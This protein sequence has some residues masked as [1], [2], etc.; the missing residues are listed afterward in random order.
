MSQYQSFPGAA[1]AS[2]TLDKLKA[3]RL[4]ELRGK[5]FLDVGCNEGFFCGFAQML[6][7]KRVVGVDH[8]QRFI[9][10]ARA[11]F[12]GC[13]FLHQ[14]WDCLP[15]GPFDVIL[16]ASALHYADDQEK[17]IHRL[18]EHLSPEGTLIVELGI[19]SSP[20]PEWTRVTRG[21][22]ER[23]FP[24]MPMLR[25]MLEGYAWKWMGPSVSQDGDPVSRHVIHINR[26]RP[27]AYLLM[28]PPGYGKSSI[29]RSLFLP[30]G[31]QVIS[32]DQ[33]IS[34]IG[35]GT[36][37]APEAMRALIT[38][39]WSPFNIDRITQDIFDQGMG[40]QLVEMWLES[41]ESGDVALDVYVPSEHGETVERILLHAGYMPVR[42]TWERAVN[43]PMSDEVVAQSAEQFYL[44][45]MDR[46]AADRVASSRNFEPQGFVDEIVLHHGRLLV[47]GWAINAG[48]SLPEGIGVKIGRRSLEVEAVEKLLR[49]DAQQHLGL[50][51]GLV[52]YTLVV[53]A[54]EIRSAADLKTISV[55]GPDGNR[56]NM[57]GR[58]DTIVRGATSR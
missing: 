17:L 57:S 26:R 8:S 55:H 6:G 27:M 14:G 10:R 49:P 29:A 25:R 18:V 5:S 12:P 28:Q 7:A 13:E 41:V 52:G 53:Q 50:P 31:I 32:G 45:L 44:S 40:S 3:L 33:T 37:D 58:L 16:L 42:L 24:S 21:D 48:G 38:E 34:R 36:K 11:R 47:R 43:P 46:D 54:P 4:P 35:R 20:R 30:A 23:L 56:F 9:A 51:H 15:D 22:D 19:V 2:R 39:D 1:G